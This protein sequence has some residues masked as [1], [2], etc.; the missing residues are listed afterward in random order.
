ME[1]E[2]TS[3]YPQKW[4][5]LFFLSCC[6]RGG[7]CWVNPVSSRTGFAFCC[8]RCHLQ[9][10]TDFILLEKRAAVTWCG[11]W[12]LMCHRVVIVLLHP[13]LLAVLAPQKGSLSMLWPLLRGRLLFPITQCKAHKSWLARQASYVSRAYEPSSLSIAALLPAWQPNSALYIW[14]VL[15]RFLLCI[16][17]QSWA[18][19]VTPPF[20]WGRQHLL[21]HQGQRFFLA[22]AL[23]QSSL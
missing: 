20:P 19:G 3:L 21:H 11:L 7:G 17:A 13:Q 23:P 1:T 15:D 9:S 12:G 4:V 10:P 22:P 16:G 14:W 8:R 2:E 18:Q 5:C 6:S